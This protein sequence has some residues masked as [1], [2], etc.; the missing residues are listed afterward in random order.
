MPIICKICDE[1]FQKI[2]TSTHLKKHSILTAQY[3]EMYGNDSLASSE[4]REAR[5]AKYKGVNNPNFGNKLLDKSKEAISIK[6]TGK[7]P[8]YWYLTDN[9]I[10]RIHRYKLRK[11]KDDPTDVTERTL[12]AAEGYKTIWDCGNSKWVWTNT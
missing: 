4:Y 5:S 9:F 7:T 2:I 1:K 11:N 12:R 8:G 10:G 6:N 3:N